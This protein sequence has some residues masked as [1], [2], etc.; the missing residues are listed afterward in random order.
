MNTNYVWIAITAVA[1]VGGLEVGYAHYLTNDPYSSLTRDPEA[2]NRFANQLAGSMMNSP[3][4]QKM[5]DEMMSGRGM[6]GMGMSGGMDHGSMGMGNM[7]SG[8]DTPGFNQTAVLERGDIAMGFDQ[9]KIMH[10]F[11]ATSTG[12]QIMIM[13]LDMNDIETINK[14]KSHIHD[15]QHEFAQGNFVKPFYIHGQVVPGAQVMMDR[16]DHIQYTV[17]NTEDGAVL[18]LTTNDAELRDAIR[19]FMDYQSSQHIGH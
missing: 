1:F 9:T 16:K 19:Q 7:H 2:M 5:M 13:A 3:A 14:I 17:K 12:G 6:G 10:H 18:V 15:I 4:H 8:Y 11:M